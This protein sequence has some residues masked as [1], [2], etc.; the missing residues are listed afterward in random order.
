MLRSMPFAVLFAIA[1]FV[2]LPAAAEPTAEQRTQLQEALDLTYADRIPEAT[3]KAYQLLQAAPDFVEAHRLYIDL[4][5]AQ[6]RAEDAIHF[7]RLALDANPDSPAAHYLYGRSTNAPTIAEGEFRAALELDPDFAWAHHGLGAALAMRGDLEGGIAEFERAIALK[8]DMTDAHNHLANLYLSQDRADDA[9]AAYRRAIEMAPDRPDAYFYLGTYFA[10][11][12]RMEEAAELLEDAVRLDTN[13]PMFYLELGCVYFDLHRERDALAAFD[14]G[15]AIHPREEYL[16]DL[17]A[18]AADIVAGAAPQEA[19]T[20]FRQ[21]LESVALDPQAALTAFEE[22]LAVAPDFYLAHL[23]RGI[24]LAALER[25]VEAEE[26]VRQALILEPRYPESHAS[27]AVLLMA[28][29]RYDEAEAALQQAL[30]LDPAHVEAL[31]GMGMVYMLQ[32]RPEL[33]ASYFM[34]A[35]KLSPVDLGLAVEVAGA[36]VQAGDLEQAEQI[37]RSVLRADPRFNFARHQLAALLAD[38]QRFDE[39]IAELEELESRVSPEVNVGAL[40][41]QVKAQRRFLDRE[42][43]PRLLLAQILVKDRAMADDIRARAAAGE[44]FGHLARS[45]SVGPTA[46]EGGGIGEMA[47]ADLNPAMAGALEGVPVGGVTAVIE[48]AAGYM[49]FKRVK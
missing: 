49:M 15:L 23:N 19:F 46:A 2:A 14:A 18:V 20:P 7:Y 21:G 27:L 34:R 31:R 25:T 39:S 10:H 13:N 4:L 16:R 17:R 35:S 29:Q 26:A 9:V 24:V 33:A 30:A 3:E 11:H 44:D 6:G 22:T 43:S 8:P 48:T 1:M 41:E 32:E 36:Y 47:L 40:I 5:A 38:Q 45:F 42:N 12:E 37:L 28:D